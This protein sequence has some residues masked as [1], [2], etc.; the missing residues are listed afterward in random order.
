MVDASVVAAALLDSGPTGAWAEREI[1]DAHCLAPQL[2]HVEVSNV[3]RREVLRGVVSE[4]EGA[5][6]YAE[7]LDLR[8]HLHPFAPH[9][10]R[11]WALRAAVTAYDAWYVALAEA[12][13]CPLSTLDTRLA[14]TPGLACEFRVPG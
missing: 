4:V 9:A 7:L 5:L 3:L 11:V 14:R 12:V 8:L 2:I 10:Q 6:M 1:L 13:G